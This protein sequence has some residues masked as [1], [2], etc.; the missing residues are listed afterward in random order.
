MSAGFQKFDQPSQPTGGPPNSKR[1]GF[2]GK[3]FGCCIGRHDAS[4]DTQP[5]NILQPRN[6]NSF[7]ELLEKSSRAREDM[8]QELG[9]LEPLVLSHLVSQQGS[10]API[11]LRTARR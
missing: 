10:Q 3:C 4:A 7:D 9:T 1:G 5:L 6:Q 2:L 11:F 8:W